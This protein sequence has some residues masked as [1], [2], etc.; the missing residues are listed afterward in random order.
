MKKYCF[1]NPRSTKEQSICIA[2]GVCSRALVQHEIGHAIGLHHE[3]SRPDRD[4]YVTFNLDNVLD[5]F[6]GQ[7]G[8]KDNVDYRGIPYDYYSV[9]HYGRYGASKNGLPVIETKDP[10]FRDVIGQIHLSMDDAA[11]VN[12]MYNCPGERATM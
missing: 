5:G 10:A 2:P 4:N 1:Q 9:M 8:V 7:F 6:R 11:V 12:L 3:Q